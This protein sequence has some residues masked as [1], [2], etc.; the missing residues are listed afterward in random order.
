[1]KSVSKSYKWLIIPGLIGLGV[2]LFL[3]PHSHPPAHFTDF[4]SKEDVSDRSRQFLEENEYL[5]HDLEPFVI[6]QTN[7]DLINRQIAHFGKKQLN[8]FIKNGFL[9]FVPSYYWQVLWIDTA[10]PDEHLDE[11]D[12][13]VNSYKHPFGRMVFKTIHAP[14]GAIQAFGIEHPVAEEFTARTRTRPDTLDLSAII[15][16]EPV[17]GN[18]AYRHIKKSVKGTVWDN[19]LMQVDSTYHSEHHGQPVTSIRIHPENDIFGHSPVVTL[20]RGHDGTLRGISH[21]VNIRNSEAPETP[22]FIGITRA[23]FYVFAMLILLVLFFRRL[24]HRLIDLRSASI[25]GIVAVGIC[26]I[27]IAHLLIQYSAFVQMDIQIMQILAMIVTVMLLSGIVGILVFI[28]SGLGESLTREIWPEKIT[29]LSLIRLGYFRSKSVGRSLVAGVMAAL[30]YLGI[31]AVVYTISDNSYLNPLDDQFFYIESYLFSPW[32]IF[33]R[34]FFWMFL[35]SIGL[36]A[37][38]ISW[39]AINNNKTIFLIPIGA[40][41]FALISSFQIDT[42]GSAQILPMIFIP[43]LAVTWIYL[44]YDLLTIFVSLFFFI[45]AWATVDGWVVRNSPDAYTAVAI[46]MVLA[47]ILLTGLYLVRYGKE[48]EHIPELTPDYIREIAREQRVERELEIAHQVHQSFLPVDLPQFEGLDIAANCRAAFDVGG[49]YYDF[50]PV[51]N[52]QMAFVIGDVSGKGIQA[53]FYMTMVKGIF[54]SLVK[55]I[56]DPAALLTRMNRL[57]YN[58]ARRGSFIS[59]CYGLIDVRTGLLQYARA[60]HNPAILIPAGDEDAFMLRSSG[61]ALGLTRGDEFSDTLKK[62]RISMKPGDTLVFYTDGLT[63]ATNPNGEMYGD[64]R[65]LRDIQS[66]KYL[67]PDEL[68]SQLQRTIDS[69][70]AG[71]PV[72]DD[73]TMVV[74]RYKKRV[75]QS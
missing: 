56:P 68:I 66:V 18:E 37:G 15:P 6:F 61:L 40:L 17:S 29:T 59:L 1:L 42:P 47:L 65:L 20:K 62:E 13:T 22:G 69:F 43:G 60:G 51:D 75:L 5:L 25:Y 14:D 45:A 53:A 58:N 2:F 74:V 8:E 39:I 57:F 7:D 67:A 44:K 34:S 48:Y 73:M 30:I 33:I 64:D 28:F 19:Y 70:T 24:F 31:I 54:Q 11:L 23:L 16:E 12:I 63:E 32:Q 38:L 72:G 46:F 71:T 3:M 35:I 49:D 52:R 41:A 26:F 10:E 4:S 55:E 50:I 9:R 27:Q 21:V 36:Y